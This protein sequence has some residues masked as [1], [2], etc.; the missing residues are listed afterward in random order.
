MIMS[1]VHAN[2]L[3]CTTLKGVFRTPAQQKALHEFIFLSREDAE[4]VLNLIDIDMNQPAEQPQLT[5]RLQ[6]LMS[7]FSAL[8]QLHRT[9]R[10]HSFSDNSQRVHSP[11]QQ[12]IGPRVIRPNP[13]RVRPPLSATARTTHQSTEQPL[14]VFPTT[15]WFDGTQT[16][17]IWAHISNNLTLQSY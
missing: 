7:T 2:F 12:A 9:H 13:N 1:L 4:V 11:L 15:R 17:M 10:P 16:C 14:S 8:P 3:N 5:L 6:P